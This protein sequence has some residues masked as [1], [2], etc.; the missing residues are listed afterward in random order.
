MLQTIASD[1]AP[2][3]NWSPQNARDPVASR[4]DT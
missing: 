2:A 1:V 3:L 4:D